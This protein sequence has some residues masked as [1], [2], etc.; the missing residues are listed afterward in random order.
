MIFCS[1]VIE[2]EKLSINIK[3]AV[4]FSL[5]IYFEQV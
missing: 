2:I 1:E 3:L 4:I 5:K